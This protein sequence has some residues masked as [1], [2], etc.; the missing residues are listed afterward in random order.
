MC[1][2]PLVLYWISYYYLFS[3]V[4]PLQVQYLWE[5]MSQTW[6]FWGLW[7]LELK[8]LHIMMAYSFLMFSFPVAIPMYHRYVVGN[9]VSD[10]I[11]HSYLIKSDTRGIFHCRKCIT[12]LEVCGSTQICIIVA[13][14]ALVCWTPGAAAKMRSGFP[15]RQLFYRFWSP[16]R[17]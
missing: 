16:Y 4:C 14:Y 12:T 5:C 8:G 9:T 6:I 13:K 2:L 11:V 3:F 7:L 1:Y 17:V 10:Q 15:A